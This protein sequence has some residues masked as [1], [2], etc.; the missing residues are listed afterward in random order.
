MV[1]VQHHVQLFARDLV[2]T[3]RSSAAPS[4]E[5]PRVE[6]LCV[7]QA[8][9]RPAP[10]LLTYPASAARHARFTVNLWRAG[11]MDEQYRVMPT[12]SMSQ[13]PPDGVF[14]DGDRLWR[15]RPGA[16]STFGENVAARRLF[17]EL[18]RDPLWNPW[19][20]EEQAKAMKHAQHV[21]EQWGRAEVGF[22]R[23]LKRQVDAEMAHAA[24]SRSMGPGPHV[25]RLVRGRGSSRSGR[26]GDR[27]LHR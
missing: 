14:T 10:C 5:T 13:V 22:E 15:A 19:L 12:D 23:R 4:G 17:S 25:R 20:M 6:A 8:P 21:M 9:S 16:T 3:G 1:R 18:H 26:P 11:L 2:A 7:G 27:W 24:F